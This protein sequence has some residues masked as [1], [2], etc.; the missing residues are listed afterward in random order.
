M[1]NNDFA[2]EPTAFRDRVL[3]FGYC[4]YLLAVKVENDGRIHTMLGF[5]PIV[6]PNRAGA[7]RLVLPHKTAR[8][9]LHD[10]PRSP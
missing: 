10:A 9:L 2:A 8:I 6:G 1:D 3:L 4:S 7:R 5:T